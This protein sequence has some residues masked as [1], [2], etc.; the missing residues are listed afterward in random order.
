MTSKKIIIVNGGPLYPLRGMYQVRVV[1]QIKTLSK[2][3]KVSFI[4]IYNKENEKNETVDNLKSYCQKIIPVQTFS[5]TTFFRALRKIVLKP[6]FKYTGFP[7]EYY[8]LSNTFTARRLAKEVD[9]L[10][11][12]VVITHYWQS[13]GFFTFLKG[14]YIRCIDTH[15]AVEENINLYK[16][17][18]YNH[19]NN[20]YLGKQLNWE[21]KLQDRYFHLSRL[22]IVNSSIQKKL[23]HEKFPDKDIIVVTNGQDLTKFFQFNGEA[24]ELPKNNIL[25]YG[26]LSNQFNNKALKRIVKNIF[27][28]LKKEIPDLHLI[29]LGSNPPEWLQKESKTQ[30]IVVTGFVD[31]IRPYLKASIVSLIPLDSGAGFRGRTIE[32]MAMGVPVIGTHNALDSIE[33][34]N[35]LHGYIE[36]SDEKIIEK[37]LKLLQDFNEREKMANNAIQF[38]KENYSLEATFG[39]LSKKLLEL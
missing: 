14:N 39:K 13:A 21:K 29:A 30:D 11:G 7:S 1:N 17:G 33:M 27:P 6:V 31:D 26:A 3:H 23:I 4:F 8:T 15:Y 24:A 16:S 20:K 25:F 12:D 34:E 10:G 19:L 36:D 5:Q 35:G 37:T 28:P 18:K 2:H 32:L 9:R 38:V 22:L